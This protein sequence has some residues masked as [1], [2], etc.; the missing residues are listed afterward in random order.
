MT[1]TIIVPCYNEQE[2]IVATLVDLLRRFADDPQVDVVVVDD[3]ST[4][5][6][7]RRLAELMA[8]EPRL[9][10]L[11]LPRNGGYGA[12]LKS[13][14]AVAKGEL[15]AILDGDGT[16]PTDLLPA[17]RAEM[18]AGGVDMVVGA[19]R[20]TR[21]FHRPLRRL[22]LGLLKRYACWVCGQPI[23]DIN[24]GLRLFRRAAVDKYV[25]LCPS[26][27]S[28]TTT[29]T[30]SMLADGRQVV[31]RPIDYRGREQGSKIRPLRD[32]L[33][34][35]ALITRLGMYFAPWRILMPVVAA[36]LVAFL[37]GFAYDVA[38]V[39]NLG[40]K[41]VLFFT[42]FLNTLFFALLAD[43]INRRLG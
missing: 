6:S 14:L 37:A 12:A 40:D 23:P 1:L 39:G 15:V 9:R 29:I 21:L 16:Y 19:R 34:F 36:S 2:T 5:D 4:D 10:L 13:G 38:V 33:G 22:A 26:G 17:W 20:Q 30:V 42:L 25:K 18:A 3:G 35:A 31:F 8:T 41:T 43:L 24:S 27:F 32:T 7:G 28:F 11:A